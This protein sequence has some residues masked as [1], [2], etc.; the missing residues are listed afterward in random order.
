MKKELIVKYKKINCYHGDGSVE[1]KDFRYRVKMSKFKLLKWLIKHNFR[2]SVG[3]RGNSLIDNLNYIEV[4]SDSFLAKNHYER[5]E[6][7]KSYLRRYM[8]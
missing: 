5:N 4:W 6:M 8:C 3:I 7:I 1:T 2:F